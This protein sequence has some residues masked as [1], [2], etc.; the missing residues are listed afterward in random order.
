MPVYKVTTKG[1]IVTMLLGTW[2]VLGVFID[3]Y[4]HNHGAVETFFTPWHAILYSG[5][6]ACAVWIAGLI[7]NAKKRNGTTWRQAIPE[8]YE[9]GLL[10]VVIFLT[11]GLC[12][13]VWHIIFGIE[14]DIEA[15]LSPSHLALMLGGILILTSPFRA[16]WRDQGSDRAV[17]KTFLPGLLSLALAVGI[18]NF[19]L[20]YVWMFSYNL[21]APN[22]IEWYTNQSS[23]LFGYR[24]LE[25]TQ[26][27]GLTY[28]LLNTIVFMYPVFLL[29]K[30]WQPPFGAITCLFVIITA[31]MSVLDGFYQLHGLF[32]SLAAG[33]SADLLLLWR[34]ADGKRVFSSRLVAIITPIVLWGCYFGWMAASEGIGWSP[35]L[36]VGSIV[37][38]SLLS[39]GLCL[40]AISPEKGSK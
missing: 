11:G 29:L 13:M 3:G 23:G 37:Q 40:L 12:D 15:L 2:L 21:A 8:G 27:R 7:V 38:A 5:F 36:W 16:A 24:I 4:A 26:V 25:D 33:L 39:L 1:H 9:L 17:W 30:R 6:L 10:G 20:M 31:L 35:E 22:V 19:F 14:V 18:V 32:I 34:R 28:I